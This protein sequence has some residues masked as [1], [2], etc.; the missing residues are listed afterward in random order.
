MDPFFLSE[1][2]IH[3]DFIGLLLPLDSNV[4]LKLLFIFV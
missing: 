2:S 4:T 3:D 1:I